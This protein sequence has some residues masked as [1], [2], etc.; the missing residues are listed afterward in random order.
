MNLLSRSTDYAVRAL[1]YMA[2]RM[3]RK[4]SS[5][6]VY[7]DLS[8]PRPFIRKTLQQLQK[9]GYLRSTRGRHGGFILGMSPENIGLI[10]LMTLFQGPVTLGDCLFRSKICECKADCPLRREI[11]IIEVMAMQHLKGVS[12]ATLMNN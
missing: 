5:A 9:A 2:K 11:K 10:D 6:D 3:P 4:S 1:I 7:R 12:I 8:L